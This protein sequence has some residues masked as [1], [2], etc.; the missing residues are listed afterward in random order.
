MKPTKN[1]IAKLFMFLVGL[2]ITSSCGSDTSSVSSDYY[3]IGS[4]GSEGGVTITNEVTS[5]K[6]MKVG[7]V[8]MLE[9]A[10][11]EPAE[12]NFEGTEPDSAYYLAIAELDTWG[13]LR[14][15]AFGDEDLPVPAMDSVDGAVSGKAY[16]SEAVA[17]DLD[18]R[19]QEI[20]RENERRIASDSRFA[21]QDVDGGL[22]FKAAAV[23]PSISVGDTREF[24]VLN[25]LTNM[26]S[27]TT[28]TAR[29]RCVEKDVVIYVD[30][31]V[32]GDKD[33]LTDEDIARLCN[34]FESAVSSIQGWFGEAS[35]VDGDG[36]V[37]ALLTPQVN[38]LGAMGGG[39]I[40]GF[41]LA[42][43]LYPR[44]SSNQVS[45]EMEIVYALVPNP[46]GKY[47]S[48]TIPK[49]FAIENFLTAVLPHEFQHV[50]SY[51]QHVLKGGGNPEENWLN[52]GLSHLTED[53]VGYGQENYS[54]ANI[55]LRDPLSYPLVGSSS[56]NLGRRGAAYLF[57]RFLYE[58]AED[59]D[60]FLWGLYHSGK[61]GVENIEAAFAGSVEN[62]D[63]FGEFLMRWA[64]AL[65][66]S[67]RGISVDP[68]YTYR[69]R[70][71]NDETKRWQ[72]ICLICDAEDG[73]GTLM[74]GPAI[75]EYSG[76]PVSL[77]PSGIGFY[78]I[79]SPSTSISLNPSSSGS[80]G[81][82]LVRY[83]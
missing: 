20:L 35:D 9:F 50:V 54:R 34:E 67:G 82:V 27:Y 19:F 46:D 8:M 38:R 71:W 77:Y 57:L 45:N 53:L 63:Q 3:G 31:E 4:G 33:L 24:R 36:K 15:V 41:F 43:D 49:D 66:I 40:T 32:E 28:V 18:E 16:D 14:S 11:G 5:P 65:V 62:F 13:G 73:R 69:P 42:S 10:Y 61:T 2:I 79:S 29:A 72:G 76:S 64:A 80:F 48:V 22:G 23:T 44:S 6:D 58:Q 51:N 26:G 55:F 25:S 70:T 37:S 83:R 81:A 75:Y 17:L 74:T 60:A 68:R 78:N 39:I 59:K 7:D 21:R 1:N 12:I 56:A 52:E 30:T 47:G